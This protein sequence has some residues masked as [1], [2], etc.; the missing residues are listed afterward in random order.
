MFQ[1]EENENLNSTSEI[2]LENESEKSKD[3]ESEG[4]NNM[5]F[6]LNR[7]KTTVSPNLQRILNGEL[8]PLT[9][10]TNIY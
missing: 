7:T 1:N 6:M 3:E 8:S 10:T 9:F 4:D 5:P 2:N